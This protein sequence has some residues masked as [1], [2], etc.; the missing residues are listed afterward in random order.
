VARSFAVDTEALARSASITGSAACDLGIALG[1]LRQ[2]LHAHSHP[3]GDDDPGRSF[4]AR[5]QCDAEQVEG[6]VE[7]LVRAVESTVEA[8]RWMAD[9]YAAADD[10]SAIR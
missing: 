10:A 3:W 4:Q 7:H 6:N 9:Q 2:E 5:H 1:S 8:L